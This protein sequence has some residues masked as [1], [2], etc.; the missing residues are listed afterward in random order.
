M[1]APIVLAQLSGSS[2]QSSATP[3]P[4][5]VAKPQS[6]QA[7]TVHL[8]GA[9]RID[10][11]DISSEKLT[12]VRI[13]DRLII[14]F[15][16][17][18]TVS[19]D[20]VFNNTGSP[21]PDVSFEVAADRILDGN[22]F[23]E[24]F[25]ITTDQSVLPAAGTPGAPGVPS[26]AN[27]GS[28]TVDALAGGTP[29]ALLAG[30]A[31]AGGFNVSALNSTSTPI[32]GTPQSIILNEDGLLEG[33]PG[34]LG[35]SGGLVTSFTGS[36]NIDFGSDFDG[37]T[38][39]FAAA[40]P[41][42]AGLSSGGQAVSLAITTIGGQPALIGYI[43]SD[44]SIAA[45]QVFVV[46][47]DA[48][49]TI[50]GS[51][52]VTLLRP[53]DHPIGGTE[54]TLNL[55]FD[56]IATDGSGDTA[57]VSVVIGV[58]DDSPVAGSVAPTGLN[59]QTGEGN[60]FV[61]SAVTASLGI[62]W[63]ADSGNS[64]VDGGSTGALVVGDRSLVF[65]GS[66]LT[67][68]A[69]L[70]LT[71]N[72]E[73]VSYALSAD[74]T[75][76]VATAGDRTVF[77]VSLSDV[78]AGS[79]TFTLLDNLDHVGPN[80]ATQP[81]TF[82]I[83]AT[84]ADGDPVASSFTVDVADDVPVANPGNLATVEEEALPGGNNE[85]G[86]LSASVSG[87]SLNI[88]WNSD[89][90]N[91]GTGEAGDRSVDFT[92]AEVAV[93]GAY[94]ETLTSLGQ[95]VRFTILATGELV[96]YTGESV[97][98][99]T[100]A[101]NVVLFASLSDA[102]NGSYN[103]TLV[104]PLDHAAGG[105][106][107]TL[108]LTFNYT[109]TDGDGDPSSSTFTVNVV[110]DVPIADSGDTSMVE[111]EG[112]PGGNDEEDG[113]GG[114]AVSGVSLNIAW[115][116][117]NGNDGNG[118]PGDRSVAFTNADVT[119][120]GAYGETL[121]SLGQQVRFA[122]L[123]TGEL[124]G[125]TGETAPT[126][127]SGPNVVFYAS[128]SDANNGEYSFTLVKPLDHAA[129]GG[130][131]T[132]AL[133]FNYTA[134]DSD[135]DTS[136][137]V[138]QVQIV[139][140]TPIANTGTK[141]TVEDESLAGGN[142]EA[143]G[144]AA[145]VSN[146]SLNIAWGADNGN[147]NNGQPGDRSVAFTS[148][149]VTVSGAYGEVLT[150]RGQTVQF[151]LLPDGT[152][153]GY[154]GEAVPTSTSASN[155][156]L[157]AT[158]SDANNGEYNFTLVK[159]L[160]HFGGNGE[161]TL[162]LTF[163]YTATD[164]DGDT[165]SSSFTVD[166]V[167]DVPVVGTPY[168][169]GVVEEEQPIVV[170]AGN[171]DF[172][173][174]GDADT[175]ITVVGVP[176]VLNDRT[177]Q[178]ANGTL[179]IAWGA[180]NANDGNGK[181]GDRAVAF[182]AAGVAA[183]EAQQ[184]TSRGAE[185]H[186][187]VF[188]INGGQVLVAY[189]GNVEP[190][191]VPANTNAAIAAHVV[192]T[193]SLSDS[194]AG[195][196]K[197][198]LIDTV[199][200]K[201]EVQ[202]EDSLAL[203]FQFT[204]TD[205]D[206]DTT[207]PASFSVKVIDDAPVAVG[208]ILTR[209]VEEEQLG[210]NEDTRGVGDGD[211]T[212]G[213]LVDLT[214]ATAGGPLNIFWG[215]DDSNV[216]GSV[217]YAGTQAAGDRS[218][219]FGGTSGAY[220]ADGA[221]SAA[222]AAQFVAVTGGNGA[223]SLADLT[224]GG[225]SLIYTLS[226]NG[227]VLT[228]T[229]AGSNQTVFTVTLSDQGSGAYVFNLSGVLDHPVSG[230]SASQEDSLSFRFTFTARD[231]DGDVA[232]D[233]FT[234]NVV[235]DSP[236]ANVGNSSTVEDE[237]LAGGNNE[238][239]GFTAS[240]SNISLNIAWGADDAND[241]TGQ[242]GD[243]SVAFSGASVAVSGAYGEALTSRGQ[244][245]QFTLLPDGTLVGYTGPIAPASTAAG[246]VVLFATLSDAGNGE[247]SFTLKQPL[248]HAAGSGE[249]TLSLTFGYTATD[250]D[251]DTSSSTFT[252]SIVDDVPVVGTPYQ[253]GVVE[254]EQWT[255]VGPGNEDTSG[256]GDGDYWAS[257]FGFPYFSDNTTETTGGTLAISWGADSANDN[258]GQPGDRGVSFTAAGIAALEA[259]QLTSRGELIHYKVFVVNGGEVLVAYTGDVAPSAVPPNTGAAIAANVVFMVG[260]SDTG[261]GSYAFTLVDTIDHPG[262]VQGEDALPLSFGFAA[263]DSD[264]DTVTGSFTVKIIDDAP[265]IGNP[266]DEVVREADLPT[267]NYDA[268]HPDYPNSTV[269]TGD[270]E[271]SW[272]ADDNNSG[273]I[274]NRSV[275]FT[276][277]Q[278]ATGLTSD[279]SPISYSISPDGT[280]LTAT[281][282]DNR[283]VF[284]VQLSDSGD[285]SYTF[286]L[287]DN[288]DHASSG[289]NDGSLALSFGFKA[290]DGD[291]DTATSSFK[292]TVLDTTPVAYGGDARTVD[293]DDLP[294]GT[295]S[296]KE[297]RI[298]SG[299]LNVS[300]GSDDANP[301][302]GGG[303]GDRSVG[304]SYATASAN[305]DAENA[306]GQNLTLKSDGQTVKYAFENGVLVGYTGTDLAN[307]TRVFEVSLSDQD[308][309]SYTF[310]LLGNL[311]HPAGA[312]ENVIRLEF[313][314]TAT[315]GDGD[316]SSDSFTVTIKDDVPVIG[317]T[318]DA[319]LTE[320]TTGLAGTEAFQTQTASNVSL[321]INWG[322][323]D[324]NSGAANRSVAFSS[325][326]DSGDVV[327]TTAWGSPALT[328]NGVTVHFIRVSDTEIWGVAN[329]NGGS[330]SL[331]DRKVFHVTLSDDGSGSY[332]FELLDNV[333]H[334]GTGQGS[335]LSLD[336][337]FTATD[338]DGDTVGSSF[339]VTINDD[340][341]R[342]SIGTTETKTVDEDGLNGGNTAPAT[343]DVAGA[344]VAATGSLAISWGA[345]DN[346][347]GTANR[348]VAFS[349][350]TN[351][352]NAT[353]DA[354]LLTADGV[355]VKLWVVGNTLYGYTGANPSGGNPPSSGS[356]V[357]T[358]TLDDSGAGSY[359][360][361]LLKNV[362][363]PAGGDENDV[364][365]TFGFTATD[366]DNDQ[367]TGN[368]TV[369]IDDDRAT[370]GTIANQSVTELTASGFSNAFQA[371]SLSN[372]SLNISWG[373]DD[374]NPTAGAGVHDRSVAF[375]ASLADAVPA[376][377][378]SNGYDLVYRLS[379][380]GQTLTAYRYENGHYLAGNGGD[381]GTSPSNSARVFSVSLSDSGNGSYNFTLYDNLDHPTGADAN[382]LP[383]N[384][385]FTAT[386]GD[387][388][389]TSGSFTVDVIDDVPQVTAGAEVGSVEERYLDGPHPTTFGNLEIDW[390]SDDR[391]VHLTF[392]S[393][394]ITDD[395]GNVL[396]LTSGGVA[397]KYA[398][399][400]ADGSTNP[401][402]Q[403]LIA[404]KDGDTPDNPVFTVNL[405]A[406][407]NPSYQF[408]LYQALDHFGTYDDTLPL[409]FGVTGHD[410]DGDTVTQTFTVTLED[411]S[412]QSNDIDPVTIE[413][414][415]GS[416]STG[417]VDLEIDFGADGDSAGASVTFVQ[418]SPTSV[419]T[420]DGAAVTLTSLGVGLIY[421]LS[422]DGTTLSAYRFNGTSFV[423][424]NGAL[425]G[426]NIAAAADAQVFT[427]TLSD[428]GTG[429]YNFTLLQPL[430]HPG[431]TG[432]TQQLTLAF[433]FRIIDA[434]GDDD[435]TNGFSVV[436]DAAGSVSTAYT[437][438]DSAVFVNLSDTAQTV[439]GQTVL[440]HSVTDRATVADK[441]VGLDRLGAI[442][443]ANGGNA[444]DILIGGVGNN[445]LFG[446][447]GADI[448]IGGGGLNTLQGGAGDDTTIYDVGI[449]GRDTV[450][451]GAD[452]DT[453]I[454]NGTSADETFNINAIN[455][456][457][458]SH[459]AAN[460][461]TTSTAADGSNYEVATA[462]VEEWIVEGGAGSDTFNI[463]GPL[464]GTGIATSTL[465]IDGDG[466]ADT[467]D[468]TNYA[469]DVRIV[470]DGG[471]DSDTV[472][473]GFD[474][475]DA[476]YAKVFAPDGVTLTGVQV[477]YNGV[478]H[479]LTNY[480]T[481][482]FADG[483]WTLPDLVNT[484]PE[485]TSVSSGQVT[486]DFTYTI[487]LSQ[488]VTNGSFEGP[489]SAAR[490]S[491]WTTSNIDLI[492]EPHSGSSS[493][494][495]YQTTGTLTQTIQTVAGVTYTISFYASNPFD[496]LGEVESLKVLWDGQ[497]AFS[498]GN[499]PASG[500]YTAFTLY[501]IT[502][503]ATGPSTT[504][505]IEMQDSRGWWVLDDVSVTAVV[506]TGIETASG[507]LSFSDVDI[508][509]VHQVSYTPAAGGYYGTFT[510]V[511]T[512]SATADG[513]GTITWTYTVNDSEIQHLA[514]GQTVTQTYTVSI[515]DGHG[516]VTTRNVD[517][518][519]HGTNDAP[520][521]TGD[522]VT[523]T[524]VG[525]PPGTASSTPVFNE[526]ENNNSRPNANVIDRSLLKVAPNANLTDATDPSIT[527]KGSINSSNT[528]DYFAISLKAGEK[529]ILD[530]D[531]R[532]GSLDS[533]L[534][535]YNSSGTQLAYND[536][537][538]DS[539]GGGGST[540]GV[541]SYVTYTAASDGTYY[542][543]VGR[544]SGSGN[545]E[546]QVSIDN[547]QWY[548]ASPLTVSAA[549]LLANDYDVDTTDTLTI[550]SVSGQGVAL[551]NGDVVVQPGVTSFTYTVRDSH[552]AESTATV[553]VD[554]IIIDPNDA[555]VLTGPG[556]AL[557]AQVEDA[558]APV[559]AAGT[560]VSDLVDLPGNG[561]HNNV[562]DP[563]AGAV[564]GIAL[565]GA[566]AANG[567][568]WYSLDNGA[569]WSNVG[570]VSGTQA[571]L[572]GENARLYFQPNAD[573]NGSIANAITYRGWDQTSGAEGSKADTSVNGGTSAFS[574]AEVS[575]SLGVDAVNDAPQIHAPA[576]ITVDEDGSFTFAGSN[577]IT[578]SDVD[579]DVALTGSISI[580][581]GT[582]TFP[583]GGTANS[584]TF[585]VTTI[586]Q[587]NSALA[588][589]VF[590][591][592]PNS[593]APAQIH[594]S[595]TDN[596]NTGSGGSLIAT[597]TITIDV[598][599]IADAPI[600]VDDSV[601][602]T[603][604]MPLVVSDP[605]QGVLA[606][607]SDPDT[608]DTISV[609]AGD[610]ATSGGGIIHFNADG[611]YSYTPKA[612]FNGIDTVEY[613][614]TDASGAT[615]TATLTIEVAAVNDAPQIHAPADITVDEDGSF[616]FGGS[617]AITF[618]DV[619]GNVALTG[620]ISITNGTLTFPSGGTANS[621]V[622]GVTTIS[623]LNAALA[624]LV[625]KPTPN[626][627]AP[628][629]IHISITDNGNTGSGG[630]LIATKTI[631]IDV[632]PIDDAPVTTPVAL[633]A[634]AEDSGAHLI[635]QAQLLANASDIDSS[636]LTAANLQIATGGGTLVDN[637][638]GT[639]TYTPAA[640]DDTAVSFSYT[641][642]DGST[643][644]PGSATL[645]IT[646]V[647]DAPVAGNDTLSSVKEDSGVR[648]ISF[649]SLLGNDSAGPANESGQT[650]TITAISNVV[651]GTAV[652]SGTNILFTPGA[653]FAGTASFDYTV[654]DDGQ[655]AGSNDFKSSVGHASFAVTPVADAPVGTSNTVATLEDQGYVFKAADFGFTDPLDSPANNF[656]GVVIS[657]L[658]GAGTLTNN[659]VAVTA[660]S[661][662]SI[663][664]I[665]AGRLLFTPAA[666]GN[667][668]DYASFT[669]RVQDDGS[670]SGQGTRLEFQ[671]ASGW[672]GTS[673]TNYGWGTSTMPPDVSSNQTAVAFA[674]SVTGS[675]IRTDASGQPN[676]I[677]TTGATY[678]LMFDHL[679]YFGY[680]AG[681]ITVD[682]YA[683]TTLIG[684]FIHNFNA[685]NP[686]ASYNTT[687]AVPAGENG[688]SLSVVF[689]ANST[690]ALD[691]VS[692]SQVV[693]PGVYGPNLLVNG[694]FGS[695]SYYVGDNVDDTPRTMTIDVTPVNDLPQAVAD[696]GA[697]DPAF[698]MTEDAGSAIFDVLAND[699]R[700][701]DDGAPNTVTISG[702]QVPNNTFGIDA[703]DLQVTVTSDNKIQVTLLGTDWNKLS[704]GSFLTIPIGYTLHG[705]GADASSAFLTLRVT[706]VNDAPVLDATKTPTI[707][708]VEDAG[709]ASFAGKVQVSSLASA[710][711]IGNVNDVDGT[712]AGIAITGASTAH[713]TWSW[714]MDGN[715][716]FALNPAG[717]SDSH[718]LLLYGNWYVYF[719]P[720]AGYDGTVSDGLTIRAWD[721]SSG[722]PGSY[723]DTTANGGSTAFSSATDTVVVT[724]TPA[725]D[726]PDFVGGDVV[727]SVT[728]Q[729]GVPPV[730]VLTNGGF[731]SGSAGWTVS[732]TQGGSYFSGSFPGEGA[733]NFS[734]NSYGLYSGVKAQLAQTVSTLPGV[735]YT[736]SFS[737]ATTSITPDAH[738]YVNWN[739]QQIAAY[740]SSQVSGGFYHTFTVTVTGTGSDTLQFVVDDNNNPATYDGWYLDAVALTPAIHYETTSGTIS[741]SDD[742]VADVHAVSVTT[743]QGSSYVGHFVPVV[744]QAG[745]TVNWTFY[746]SDAELQGLPANSVDQ[747]Y[748]LTISDGN[749]GF[750]TQDV[751]VTLVKHVNAS[752]VITSSA[753]T[754]VETE[755][756]SLS[757]VNLVQNPTF[758]LPN[759]F[760]PVLTPWTVAGGGATIYG[761]G[762]NGSVNSLYLSPESSISQTLTT[763]VGQTYT[764]NYFLQNGG[765]P[766]SV[767]VNGT[768]IATTNAI[769]NSWTEYSV[770]FV[771][772]STSTVLSFGTTGVNG[773]SLD[774]IS[775][776][777]G[778]SHV[779][780][781]T[782][783]SKGT[784]TYTDANLVDTHT[785]S[786]G[787]PTFTWSGG[788]LS[789]A[790]ITALTNASSLALT[791][792]DSAG[793]GT[794]SV[795]W[796]HSIADSAIQ[797][798]GGGQTLT[799][800]YTVSIDD[801]RGGVTSQDVTITI[802]GVNDAA[803]ISGTAAGTV[804]EDGTLIAGGTLSVDD[805][806][807]GQ[808]LFQT[809]TSL[810]GT[811]GT[812]TFNT[813][814]GVWGYTLNNSASNVQDLIANQVVHDTLI[815]TSAD[816]TASRTIDV[817]I[818]G[819][820]EVVASPLTVNDTTSASGRYVFP[821]ENP[822]MQSMPRQ[823][824]FDATSLF[825]GGVGP[826]SY[827]YT[828]VS[829]PTDNSGWLTLNGNHF[830]GTPTGSSDDVG[831]YVYR[832]TA[833]DS[834]G[835]VSTY[836]AFSALYVDS[837]R[838]EIASNTDANTGNYA[839]SDVLVLAD[840]VTST[841]TSGGMD[842][843]LVGASGNNS[844]DGGTENDAIYGMAGN[845]TLVGGAGS[846]FIDGG[847]GDDTITG[848]LNSDVLLGGSGND[849]F[850]YG[851]NEGNDIIDGGIGTDTLAI[852]GTSSNDVT[853]AYLTAGVI[854]Q[855]DGT[856]LKSIESIT[857]NFGSGTDR[858][859][860]VTTDGVVVNLA[861]G[862]ATGFTS[863]TGLE[864]VVGG[865][866]DDTLIGNSGSN[867]LSGGVGNDVLQGGAGN[868][869]LNGGSGRDTFVFNAVAGTSTD[870]GRV[871]N[872]N[873]DTGQDTIVGFSATDDTIK[874]VA[875]NV[876]S[877]VHETNTDVNPSGFSSA[878]AVVDLGSGD[879]GDV[880]I[881]FSG[882]T[883]SDSNFEARLQY[884]LTGTASGD[885]LTGGALDDVL[886]GG[887]GGDALSG[888]GGNDILLGGTGSD[889]LRGGSGADT[890][891]WQSGDLNGGGVDSILDYNYGQGDSID[892]TGLLDALYGG[893]QTS[894]NVR[895]ADGSNNNVSVQ[896]DVDT[897][898]GTSWQNIATLTGFD[899]GGTD[900][901]N[902]VLNSLTNQS[903][904]YTT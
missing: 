385:G 873:S 837:W 77:T 475:A 696:N 386:D 462:A 664:D 154:T 824:D 165:S 531:N 888:G 220:I 140:D 249:N 256:T 674:E 743:P 482:R 495:V 225:E 354:G 547:M 356:R 750:D 529:L 587:L 868:D 95:Q 157:F 312:G 320:N 818:Q 862:T 382:T 829:S 191:S 622:F 753:Q 215:G 187:K 304:F 100:G 615:D 799:G 732:S 666:N 107:N 286:T 69:A 460:I 507:T 337:G 523:M 373:A 879:G 558:G 254:E 488:R 716:W 10:F 365:L 218:V 190:A 515:D 624:N 516:G 800:T 775:V 687:T 682:V 542:I 628:A 175:G 135:G 656:T 721:Q 202:G 360:F 722:T 625:F 843:V 471:A 536:D 1:N 340:N 39:A 632:N 5:K 196:Y 405:I 137:S 141:S 634:I 82:A 480:E 188:T 429:S 361:T 341:G 509:D 264:G 614:V 543:A 789:Q 476:T 457:G 61:S 436:V 114:A 313:S 294:S 609:V 468:L 599:P 347:S 174:S 127:I 20:P 308:D 708:L 653:N 103:L 900:Q 94:G 797:F 97:P 763:V 425:L 548:D 518:Q 60:A 636:T 703:S 654:Q 540:S 4:L 677:A 524:L 572:L 860:Y 397:L 557:G 878:T 474:K 372:V 388:D 297:P 588:N 309:G 580:T 172:G 124:V 395:F 146:V 110:D 503:V 738:F 899:T 30:E 426:S 8:D 828:L 514:A 895:L 122:I 850:N 274:S 183:L 903:H 263:T 78:G 81:L 411:W 335:A 648:I 193:V 875:T 315:D 845:D 881:T 54:D 565:T 556:V 870:S 607:D 728:E 755:D 70:G 790:Q 416:V 283:V 150:S 535:L 12:F 119:V 803:S 761:S 394:T 645:D 705:D 167:D 169:D 400:P 456:G 184:L 43:G 224:S 316:T 844:L 56:I 571:L 277:G 85:E 390:N 621:I 164:S 706:G 893:S 19:I 504:L 533:K 525:V 501:S 179:A 272:G 886:N 739:G 441:V 865:S 265:V 346:N 756:A 117:D 317:N 31:G 606:N 212:L 589:L 880:V 396:A 620:S 210:G 508:G 378:T 517:I 349:G 189:T 679:Q 111:D 132:L 702:I 554:Q 336:I 742:D 262:A 771:A 600:A 142:N 698:R 567:T 831:Q 271:I 794:G 823:I 116:A 747:V 830:S 455:L 330:L 163:G 521:A 251:G 883:P 575:S 305:V 368:F 544:F 652:I 463:T 502:V 310:T 680:G 168:Q 267:T 333:D 528:V 153:V 494:G 17:Q 131:N 355:Q 472:K 74:G 369:T 781:G 410:G 861:A 857:A 701:A 638:D 681:T 181:P 568:W 569:T 26:G 497:T 105:E 786:A 650:L 618:S 802:N 67:T 758:E 759:V 422:P 551:V 598:N 261:N 185:I 693:S 869:S 490:L 644:V 770:T 466:G 128:L 526:L 166:I 36:L 109:A 359:S 276:T 785:V 151:A 160:D 780:A 75:S 711:G 754:G 219:V 651:G 578:F 279:G 303:L 461:D 258:N 49:T 292:V 383:L 430:D 434:D 136:S 660:G 281:T 393:T 200:H 363:H 287:F 447:G 864:N 897:T 590:K 884:D 381:L 113:V 699:T 791:A 401:L 813:T 358:V 50:A 890:F 342:P 25:P 176:V 236:I 552:G 326:I 130:E 186:Y 239:D 22:Q 867:T 798:L 367:V 403:K 727:G 496:S 627:E 623:Q 718:A 120:V 832:V 398:I 776:Q 675:T 581:N 40:Q 247:Y 24:L 592:M 764:V 467:L 428:A 71:S 255:V 21:L 90:A 848:G 617:D 57:P 329:D 849:T 752:P 856:V 253:D 384:F 579:G 892:L 777:A 500:S 178:T 259:Q 676:A 161:N 171:E 311:D 779:V 201:G 469:H 765:T 889:T 887:G 659:G 896:I 402:D 88:D 576:G 268:N 197:F 52:T 295:D 299:D 670:V 285:G 242:P 505:T 470:S 129:G 35:D 173:G 234:V 510:P 700:D 291:G 784:I 55:S 327:R 491:G 559:G 48:A 446:N 260:M 448:L 145:S 227:T 853:Y 96:G 871:N 807:A 204:A 59:E 486:E 3:K 838:L 473:F 647:N 773:A 904:T 177:T 91:T 641:V 364:N 820:N 453:Q 421:V 343:G 582:L 489:T 149:N 387:G 452:T 604:D 273:A 194:G 768:P 222:V 27:F 307:G 616:T 431:A 720:A 792:T 595:I 230:S 229:T 228:A 199:D 198:T 483:D 629:Q 667:G 306:Y 863:T 819:A 238:A 408:V 796:K 637:H 404:Y 729:V 46:T 570:N 774:E 406:A 478:T 539:V 744:D 534:W 484:P 92:N 104:K 257:F 550:V 418:A 231:G 28:F 649:A 32:P 811:Y 487:P 646:P 282:A 560:K 47:L 147:D 851:V 322:A 671:L 449:G 182:T 713:G 527:V 148:A 746:A 34:G 76:I 737:V 555:P 419:L 477:T 639:W 522:T 498:Q 459:L 121:T 597:K 541:D 235:D 438:P 15:D 450:D 563:D 724:V 485:F 318:V 298:V 801:G 816:G 143:D 7:V 379:A 374:A 839:Y 325:S 872:G 685:A 72:G 782:E 530:I 417:D 499:I 38:L 33:N 745:N 112:L 444:G 840:A 293:E 302:S 420:Q 719:Q 603:E 841:V 280:L 51:Y 741:F 334:R 464:L 44:P 835:S 608:G 538:Y 11:S 375:A 339:T 691:N 433:G 665:N 690:F 513:Q 601:S 424:Q 300:W 209:T 414:A 6:G 808:N 694:D 760:S 252:V 139:D 805:A 684:H 751:T 821:L 859:E 574:T 630:S 290:T 613:T 492:S 689:T 549:T 814:T 783:S 370:I 435:F 704:G 546:L 93:T 344:N 493:V 772:S 561:G 288:L 762:A 454:I 331:N 211:F 619:D 170:G 891:K 18:S 206:G 697:T 809:P 270:L 314:Y 126:A 769:L 352:Q 216:G 159:T 686:T 350:I 846:D 717:L 822:N 412:P 894:D 68:L 399:V 41:G 733:G 351:G 695:G 108:S 376:G 357:F 79:Y 668:A 353:S 162:S 577:A 237:S 874:I 205:S 876:S 804:K 207:E 445:K 885:T 748:T 84:D 158:L 658:P 275:E 842:D 740:A 586:S 596:G 767:S 99:S 766:F 9:T 901:V 64:S 657:T 591:P 125:Y 855:I 278:G 458:I 246:N 73:T 83:V 214:T 266:D 155:V 709:P 133:N 45:N 37:R 232:R 407:G 817:T 115:G 442:T 195:S 707:T 380:D 611:T 481:F 827:S 409:T 348:S 678:H 152:L 16:N 413:E 102:G 53:L 332:T 223:I 338:A 882:G 328:S 213:G 241:G 250:S 662:V 134:T 642:S 834:V 362:D 123:A 80:G 440:A 14:L 810:S 519:L 788:T 640:N 443:M 371:Q 795:A 192:F 852:T 757:V 248:D 118:Q 847:A 593:E 553:Q 296:A 319:T 730:S 564:T 321:A 631:T 180:D 63:G 366:S 13:G 584:I 89:D 672:T 391:N 585:G 451:G 233:T 836:V 635:T 858:L 156:V 203:Q 479:L 377:I 415:A 661:L 714:S 240:V 345:D 815:V 301:T 877:F 898:A 269:Q 427:V 423:G 532:T 806:D 2:P 605:A 778:T 866:G 583:S 723:A 669:F 712:V 612:D 688:N 537:D 289:P 511:I 66:A 244:T 826:V 902:V 284:T 324:N 389:V 243:R 87:V 734:A 144:Y 736:L 683:G 42:L 854:T 545:Y 221:I 566:N 633:A 715:T 562:A 439:N 392:T 731:E 226:A 833:T 655:T 58:N 506:Q 217:G 465:T 573:W 610:Y 323:D 138:F 245:V 602:A 86:F 673:G 793:T 735:Q 29:L 432:T 512:D 98:T 208:T 437:A 692:L 520:V 101:T 825:S 812:F 787:G 23:A 594:I 65:A 106:Q 643:S 749:G 725:N 726:A 626:S 710:S 62:A 663:A